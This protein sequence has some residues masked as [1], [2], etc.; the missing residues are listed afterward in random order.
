[1]KKIGFP[2]KRLAI[3]DSTNNYANNQLAEGSV[4]EGTVFLAEYQTSGKGQQYNSWE[5]E[6]GKNL[7]FSLVLLPSFVEIIDQFVISKVVTLGMT[8]YLIQCGLDEVSIKWP[9]DLY[10]GNRKIAGILIENAIMGAVIASSVIGIGLN[11]NQEKFLSLAPNPVSMKMLT[12]KDYDLNEILSGLMEGI[13][14]WYAVLCAGKTGIIN[15][16]YEQR[17]YRRNIWAQY[18]KE[19]GENFEGKI[20]G[21]NEIGQLLIEDRQNHLTAFHFKEVSFVL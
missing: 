15:A 9:N 19:N 2:V 14:N 10:V 12:G 18:R 1:M 20:Q 5:S 11:V 3:I 13:E 21:V 7:T 8:D 6:K 17:M 4:T 16:A